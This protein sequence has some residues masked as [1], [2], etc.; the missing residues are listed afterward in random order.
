MREPVRLSVELVVGECA[1]VPRESRS[2]GVSAARDSKSSAME[3]LR[4]YAL[5]LPASARRVS[6]I[7]GV[8]NGRREILVDASRERASSTHRYES[9]I[10]WAS[11]SSNRSV[12]YSQMSVKEFD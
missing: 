2:V 12:A 8:V 11:D 9:T 6:R 5:S 7:A 10:D 1:T 4:S 3:A